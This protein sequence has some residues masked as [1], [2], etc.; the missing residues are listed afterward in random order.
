MESRFIESSKNPEKSGLKLDSSGA[1]GLS[2]LIEDIYGSAEGLIDHL[3][4]A[5]EMLFYLEDDTFDKREIQAV[6]SALKGVIAAL[7]AQKA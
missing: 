2:E 4:L 7:Q 3:H 6:V 5:I 1:S